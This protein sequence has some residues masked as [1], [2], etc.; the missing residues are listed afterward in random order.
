M[1]QNL[2]QGRRTENLQHGS[3]WI[4][5]TSILFECFG[6]NKEN[7]KFTDMMQSLSGKIDIV[8]FRRYIFLALLNV[9]VKL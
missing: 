7:H 9:Y 2:F 8:Q 6:E 4:N 3:D 5:H 1:H